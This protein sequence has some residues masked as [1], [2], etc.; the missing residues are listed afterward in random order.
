MDRSGSTWIYNIVKDLLVGTASDWRFFY[1]QENKIDETLS[2]HLDDGKKYVF[3]FHEYTSFSST[4]VD[5]GK[6]FVIYTQRDIR[7]VVSSLMSFNQQSFEETIKNNLDHIINR[8][9]KWVECKNILRIEYGTIYNC[10][11]AAIKLLVRDLNLEYD[12][13]TISNLTRKHS[14]DKVKLLQRSKNIK[15]QTKKLYNEKSLYHINHITDGRVGRFRDFLSSEQIAAIENIAIDYLLEEGYITKTSGEKFISYAQN[16]ED[17]ILK[18]VFNGKKDGFYVDIGAADP[19]NLSVTKSFYDLGWTGVNIEPSLHFFKKLQLRRPKDINLN[20]AA[21]NV[22]GVFDLYEVK[23]FEECSSLD[24]DIAKD[25]SKSFKKKYFKYKVH[26]KKVSELLKSFYEREIDFLKIDVEGLEK[27]VI[28]GIDFSKI[29]PKVI[30]V[31]AMSPLTIYDFN[32]TER[33]STWHIWEPLLQSYSYN[34]VHFDGLNRFYVREENKNLQRFFSLPIWL[35]D[36]FELPEEPFSNIVSSRHK[37]YGQLSRIC[38][39]RDTLV[40]E[41]EDLVKERDALVQ[42]MSALVQEKQILVYRNEK[43]YRDFNK[44]KDRIIQKVTLTFYVFAEELLRSKYFLLPLRIFG[45]RLNS[46]Y[47]RMIKRYQSIFGQIDFSDHKIESANDEIRLSPTLEDTKMDGLFGSWKSLKWNLAK[48]KKLCIVFINDNGFNF[49][50]GIALKRQVLSFLNAGHEIQCIF[51]N[52]SDL[53]DFDV[54]SFSGSFKEMYSLKEQ[55][56]DLPSYLNTSKVVNAVIKFSPDLVIS[57]NFHAAGW[58]VDI[59]RN[60]HIL[61][62]PVVAYAHDCDWATGG[63]AHPL[64]Y[65]C[66]NYKSGCVDDDCPKPLNRYPQ[67]QVGDIRRQFITRNATFNSDDGVPIATNSLWTRQVFR[68]A[69]SQN[70]KIGIVYLGIDTSIFKP[71]VK[72]EARKSLGLPEDNFIILSGSCSLEEPGKGGEYTLKVMEKYKNRKGVHI[73]TFGH[74]KNQVKGSNITNLSYIN[75][76]VQLSKVYSAADVFVNP[77]VVE[78]FGQTM[79]EA[80][81]C[82]CPII[83]FPTCGVPEIARHNENA[84]HVET[85]DIKALIEAI[86]NLRTNPELTNQL[87]KRGRKIAEKEFTLQM[88]YN[89]WESFIEKICYIICKKDILA[90][91]KTK[92]SYV[93]HTKKVKNKFYNNGGTRLKG[94]FK[95]DRDSIPLIT[96][97]MV[98]LNQKVVVEKTILSILEQDYPNIE[99]IVIDGDSS[100]GTIDIIRSYDDYIDFWL[101]EKDHGIYDAMNKAA[102]FSN[103]RW[104]IYINADDKFISTDA[105]SKVIGCASQKADVV[106]GHVMYKLDDGREIL[107]RGTCFEKKWEKLLRGEFFTG[108]WLSGL[109]PHQ[110]TFV[111]TELVRKHKFDTNFRI[112]ADWELLFRLRKAGATFCN[113]DQV[114]AIYRAGGFSANEPHLW[115][116]DVWDIANKYSDKKESINQYFKPIYD[117]YLKSYQG[118]K[119]D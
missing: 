88:S 35:H 82:G 92:E 83:C 59:L 95:K 22:E 47:E 17:V 7:D 44:Y 14:F 98:V 87:G 20:Y 73:I 78:S 69:Y 32:D 97:A 48:R 79:L 58:S 5:K 105:I 55:C 51:W 1:L 72:S 30:L 12:E 114:A 66:E 13:N 113:V 99:F 110:A 6:A 112:S 28:E 68:E 117:E 71:F 45:L 81:A 102:E 23:G 115:I 104:I 86:E 64:W 91:Y 54:S 31:E 3:K 37:T 94:I 60:L 61:G 80:S 75:S 10:P 33:D 53:S 39:Q 108:P 96:V 63:C 19:V 90:N 27:Q 40:K 9:K 111:K 89:N 15:N 2:S 52:P 38:S 36:D 11:N 74:L 18:R 56:L 70:L 116:K 109:P 43:L 46:Y 25:S 107:Q 26:V 65:G 103:G 4:L 101:S 84:I 8:H 76:E 29:R 67:H 93:K 16:Y 100:D 41:R 57:G 106:F 50:A 119:S 24:K 49:G 85:G 62:I 34:F 118:Q 42:E 77:V 21:G